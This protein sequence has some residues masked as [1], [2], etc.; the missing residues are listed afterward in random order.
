MALD[1]SGSGMTPRLQVVSNVI[2]FWRTLARLRDDDSNPYTQ[3]TP[4][5]PSAP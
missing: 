1:E 2:S 3:E 5:N 4:K